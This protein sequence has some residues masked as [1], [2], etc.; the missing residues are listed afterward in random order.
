MGALLVF[1]ALPM[2]APVHHHHHHL[3]KTEQSGIKTIGDKERK[4]KNRIS[5]LPSQSVSQSK[6]HTV[7]LHLC[8]C[9]PNCVCCCCCFCV[10]LVDWDVYLDGRTR[11][12]L[13]NSYVMSVDWL[14]DSWRLGC[15]SIKATQ[16]ESVSLISISFIIIIL[17][18][19][20]SQTQ[21]SCWGYEELRRKIE[22]KS[23]RRGEYW[24]RHSRECY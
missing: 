14:V 13:R 8:V 9:A 7:S 19:Y 3:Q 21:N 17:I 24:T 22:S 5:F 15:P 6:V 12:R 11:T 10:C 4:K 1:L 20:S 23:T 16:Q 2:N 18:I